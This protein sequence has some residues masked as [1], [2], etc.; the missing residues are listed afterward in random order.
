MTIN[1]P[2]KT[3]VQGKKTLDKRSE[4]AKRLKAKKK[5]NISNFDFVSE[6][7]SIQE[8]LEKFYEAN[9]IFNRDSQGIRITGEE[10]GIPTVEID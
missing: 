4:L 5:Q 6:S 8:K 1:A 9:S 2:Q 3:R 7:K 10:D